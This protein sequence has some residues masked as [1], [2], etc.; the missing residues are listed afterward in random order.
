MNTGCQNTKDI[1]VLGKH[2]EQQKAILFNPRCKQW[3]CDYCAE[4]NKDYWIHQGTR[5]AM[6]I[7]MEGRDI[8]F[9]TLTSRGYATPTSSLYFFAKNW[10]KLN[11][12]LKYHTDKYKRSLGYEWSY[13]L[14]PEHHKSGVAHFHLFAATLYNTEGSWKDFAFGTGFGF[15]L[16]VQTLVSSA[17]AS[18]YLAKYLHKGTGAENW[19]KGFR[20]VRHSVN[21]P[22]AHE[23]PMEG[24]TWDTYHNPDTIWLEKNALINMGWEV[25]D[26][27]ENDL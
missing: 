14:V 23:K 26:T 6:L 11:R 20:R 5:G 24:W 18:S 1:T 4:L 13:F 10:P 7:M 25:K 8:Q 27:R 16:D 9:V 21:W 3:N 22:I 19:P 17:S 12:R 15:I 2:K